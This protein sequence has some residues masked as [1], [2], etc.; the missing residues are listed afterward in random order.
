MESYAT[1]TASISTGLAGVKTARVSATRNEKD[2]VAPSRHPKFGMKKRI[3][4]ASEAIAVAKTTLKALA[5][6]RICVPLRTNSF[7]C[8]G[9]S[10]P[11][12]GVPNDTFQG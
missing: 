5:N 6:S 3:S 9:S 8:F 11:N 2:I 4:T 10:E 7:E 1:V 12:T